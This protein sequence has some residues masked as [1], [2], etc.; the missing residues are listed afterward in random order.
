MIFYSFSDLSQAGV[1][2]IFFCQKM[3]RKT[4]TLGKST[5][6]NNFGYFLQPKSTSYSLSYINISSYISVRRAS[7]EKVISCLVISSMN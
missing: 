6:G 7:A 3:H 2:S 5:T 4:L 1:T